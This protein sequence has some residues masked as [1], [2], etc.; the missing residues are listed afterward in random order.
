MPAAQTRSYLNW[1]Q[2]VECVAEAAIAGDRDT[3]DRLLDHSNGKLLLIHAPLRRMADSLLDRAA[4]G[5]PLSVD[6]RPTSVGGLPTPFSVVDGGRNSTP[7][8]D[9]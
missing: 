8:S 7:T 1:Y 6:G 9:S 5:A 4:T 3:V 2:I